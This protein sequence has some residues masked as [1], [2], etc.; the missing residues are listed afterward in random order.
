MCWSGIVDTAAAAVGAALAPETGGLSLAIPAAFAAGANALQGGS[1]ES[2]ALAGVGGA[3]GGSSALSGLDA[4][5]NSGI[6]A[7]GGIG[8]LGTGQTIGS[9]ASG[10][11]SS[12]S[13][14]I[15]NFGSDVSSGFNNLENSVGSLF[16]S[17]PADAAEPGLSGLATDTGINGGSLMTPAGMAENSIMGGASATGNPLMQADASMAANAAGGA[18][19]SLGSMLAN[20]STT[21][22]MGTTAPFGGT[23]SAGGIAA[24]GGG[25][26]SMGGGSGI[27]P[28]SMLS[29]S[30]VNDGLANPATG[31]MTA[32]A[33]AAPTAAAGGSGM[34]GVGSLLS[35]VSGL[36]NARTLN[37]AEGQ[38]KSQQELNQQQIS[39]YLATG[40]TATSNL[41]GLLNP[42][43]SAASLASTPGYQFELQQGNNALNNQM[44]ASGMTGSGSALKAAQQFGQGL[45]GTT[46]QNAVNNNYQA[47]G[48]GLG[49]VGS[50]AGYNTALGQIGAAGSIGQNNNLLAALAGLMGQKSNG[51]N[52]FI[53]S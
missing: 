33:T 11:G 44:A 50:N 37:N 21:P 14:G 27:D 5:G 40:N 31:G 48:Q 13:N 6:D 25:L 22:G 4:V 15:S 32:A 19:N 8:S 26:S 18:S 23:P 53:G 36:A 41:N 20:G 10:F 2:D 1:L 35:G 29:Q 38:L 9:L 43:T 30:A 17:T 39:P 52:S 51:L 49:A 34:G 46:Y 7:L 47:A 16:G 28:M 42:G 45:A 24:G 12:L 3:F